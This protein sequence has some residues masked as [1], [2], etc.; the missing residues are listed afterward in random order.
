MTNSSTTFHF[1]ERNSK[2]LYKMSSATLALYFL[3]INKIF[4]FNSNCIYFFLKESHSFKE[5]EIDLFFL[6][7]YT[8]MNKDGVNILVKLICVLSAG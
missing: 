1:N 3:E 8:K 5:Y 4:T 6:N 2:L 7:K